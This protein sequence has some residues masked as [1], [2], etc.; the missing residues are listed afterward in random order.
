MNIILSYSFHADMENIHTSLLVWDFMALEGSLEDESVTDRRALAIGVV[1][2]G[3]AFDWEGV[4]PTLARRL[5]EVF[6][7]LAV[8][9]STLARLL[10][11]FFEEDSTSDRRVL[12]FLL[13]KGA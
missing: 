11:V 9:E 1:N 4:A 13:S 8:E 3:T 7:T 6:V 2:L 10:I 5:V 12:L